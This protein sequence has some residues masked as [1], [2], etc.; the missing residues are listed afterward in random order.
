M[1]HLTLLVGLI[2]FLS[3]CQNG[4]SDNTKANETIATQTAKAIDY[5]EALDKVFDQH[6]SVALWKTMNTMSYEIVKEEGNE[7]GPTRSGAEAGDGGGD[8]RPRASR[9]CGLGQAVR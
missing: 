3:A 5:P 1:K 8:L 9:L 6:G 7:R 4:T 2:T